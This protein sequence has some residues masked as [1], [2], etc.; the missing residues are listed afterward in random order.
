ELIAARARI[1]RPAAAVFGDEVVHHCR[2]EG[3]AEVHH[4]ERDAE[5]LGDAARIEKVVERATTAFLAA[6]A[7]LPQPHRHTD[8]V[9]ALFDQQ[10]RSKRAVDAAAHRDYDALCTSRLLRIARWVRHK[11]SRVAAGAMPGST[12][13][14]KTVR[15]RLTTRPTAAAV[16]SISSALVWA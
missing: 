2:L 8:D 11:E 14:L 16:A 12:L 1:G 6:L 15:M 9:I 4:I 3:A 13:E 5:L 10:R 7:A